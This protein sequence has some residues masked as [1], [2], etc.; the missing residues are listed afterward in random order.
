MSNGNHSLNYQIHLFRS[1]PSQ[2]KQEMPAKLALYHLASAKTIH[3][4][5][6]EEWATSLCEI[7][8]GC[9]HNK[10]LLNGIMKNL[11]FKQ[12]STVFLWVNRISRF[13]FLCSL[14][15]ISKGKWTSREFK[16]CLPRSLSFLLY[17]L[18]WH[19]TLLSGKC[20]RITNER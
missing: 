2:H 10:S 19:I 1:Y 17:C 12:V 4:S 15:K 13:S 7:C 9:L 8:V 16:M 5:T 14:Q 20:P 11:S 3:E 18:L 6:F